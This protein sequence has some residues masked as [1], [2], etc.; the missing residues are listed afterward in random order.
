VRQITHVEDTL[1][2]AL[3]H[4]RDNGEIPASSSPG[5]L[6]RFLVVMLQGL[7]V[8]NRAVADPGPVRD[9]I[10]VAMSAISAA[11]AG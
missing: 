9:A 7:H 2:T 5:Q 6:A 3:E 10:E 8:Y 4:A 11:S 1:R